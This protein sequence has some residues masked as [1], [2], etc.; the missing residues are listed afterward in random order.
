MYV[1][2]ICIL[3]VD[4]V[5]AMCCFG[6]CCGFIE[7]S[8]EYEHPVEFWNGAWAGVCVFRNW[9]TR[10]QIQFVFFFSSVLS[11]RMIELHDLEYYHYF[12]LYILQQ[13]IFRSLLFFMSLLF[14][15]WFHFHF[16]SMASFLIELMCYC[17]EDIVAF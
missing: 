9:N 15:K 10:S 13:S 16:W 2:K 11:M 14:C 8:V 1:S 17:A 4:S 3:N 7:S 6:L 12:Y 5:L